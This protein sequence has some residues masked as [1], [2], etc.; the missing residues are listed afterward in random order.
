M[1]DELIIV[2]DFINRAITIADAKLVTV[3]EL[4]KGL[5]K[6]SNS[7]KELKEFSISVNAEINTYKKVLDV[8][9]LY[10]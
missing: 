9:N 6:I 3:D 4:I 8:I 10:F 7:Y 5:D 1:C 2:K